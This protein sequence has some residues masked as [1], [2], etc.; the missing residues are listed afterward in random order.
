MIT[1]RRW[2]TFLGI[3]LVMLLAIAVE[4]VILYLFIGAILKIIAALF[5]IAI[6]FVAIDTI[7]SGIE[8]IER[9]GFP[10]RYK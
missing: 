8:K 1:A 6:W 3:A 5:A 10:W 9:S 4:L 2:L 7:K